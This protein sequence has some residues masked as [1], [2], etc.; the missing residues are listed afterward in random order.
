MIMIKRITAL[1]AGIL[2]ISLLLIPACMNP[3]STS[4][5]TATQSVQGA[6][7][8]LDDDDIGYTGSDTHSTVTGNLTLPT[9]GDYETTITWSSDTPSVI[10]NDGTVTRPPYGG[11]NVTVTLTATISKG[12]E[13]DTKTFT[14]TVLEEEVSIP[15]GDFYVS[16]TGQD[17]N[18]GSKENPFE[19]IGAAITAANL[20][21]GTDIICIAA[22]TY[23]ES[24][25]L[26]TGTSL[27]GGFNADF[28][29]RRYGT[30]S[31]RDNATYKTVIVSPAQS[32][33]TSGSPKATID[34]AAGPGT[35]GVYFEGLVINAPTGSAGGAVAA[36]K[37]SAAGDPP[38][39]RNCTITGSPDKA[40]NYSYGIYYVND[41][42]EIENN[43]ISA[44]S[45]ASSSYAVWLQTNFD[46]TCDFTDNT[47]TCGDSDATTNGM[48]V[49]GYKKG[50]VSGNT[51][52]LGSSTAGYPS[53]S[54]YMSFSGCALTVTEN[55]LTGGTIAG[56]SKGI[57]AALSKAGMTIKN[58]TIDIDNGGSATGLYIGQTAGSPDTVYT[59]NNTI[60][61]HGGATATWTS[62]IISSA[63]DDVFANNTIII[64]GESGQAQGL[65]I[66]QSSSDPYFRNN[67]VSMSGTFSSMKS[68]N[69]SSGASNAT[70][71][72]EN[73]SYNCLY[74][75]GTDSATSGFIGV[76]NNISADPDL[77]SNLKLQAG[78]PAAA[79]NGC[80]DMSSVF[81]TDK[82]GVTRTTWCMGA[83]VSPVVST[84]TTTTTTTTTVA[85][86]YTVEYNANSATDGVI[87][88]TSASYNEND[89]VTVADNSGDLE[90]TG[91]I[92]SGWNTAS[93][94][95]G[96]SYA[97]DETFSMGTANVILY[98]EWTDVTVTVF[99][100]DFS[101]DGSLDGTTPD[102]G[103]NW[104]VTSGSITVASGV[105][106]TQGSTSMKLAYADFTRALTT[107][108][109]LKL[110]I[111]TA[112]TAGVFATS[113]WAGISLYSGGSGGT[114]QI[115]MGSLGMV[116]GWGVD[117]SMV[118]KTSTSP[119]VSGE[120][121]NVQFTY[122]YD[123]GAWTFTIGG[124]VLS[125]TASTGIAFNTVRIG[126]DINNLANIAATQIIAV[127]E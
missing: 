97:P 50:A 96:T 105:A 83:Y 60:V 115:F 10:A 1:L 123:S 107:G 45:T 89:T 73:T 32:G 119:L 42:C 40:P 78:S 38:V 56:D 30:A 20:Q 77:D 28:T 68:I 65:Y 71:T 55:T 26:T 3:S 49:S 15:D 52:S 16:K 13:S 53:S 37:V 126:C 22:G 2:A 117:G 62:G 86:T 7:D 81:T 94:G 70:V 12:G 9:T 98:A 125:G 104:N 35:T 101:T 82:D 67:I 64:T 39:I 127:M 106:D 108:E 72:E 17:S 74:V 19:T 27:L 99:S 103:G 25:M 102:I 113:G 121:Q 58:N 51:I 4:N 59:Y 93:N 61:L 6:K 57:Y 41:S 47:I 124:Q 114:E 75:D 116:N 5:M 100:E 36:L 79:T 111:N 11:G 23:T 95:S 34:Y 33:G 76:N 63:V 84:T 90:R 87:P 91:Y 118:T 92:W 43:S 44:G 80:F 31:D 8:N 69:L 110:T 21:M 29:D 24:M 122:D 18:D 14:F 88:L 109:T 85:P 120:S 48:Y 54:T 46:H 112:E 66:N